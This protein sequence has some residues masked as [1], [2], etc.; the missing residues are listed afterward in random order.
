MGAS[1]PSAI[2][3]HVALRVA[4]AD[5]STRFYRDGLGLA[6]ETRFRLDGRRFV[7][8][9]APGGGRV[10][11]VEVGEEARSVSD[12]NVM[13]HFALATPDVRAAVA[14]AI[15]AGGVLSIPATDR[16]IVDDATSAA[17]AV[18]IA[19]VRGP[20]AEEIELVEELADRKSVV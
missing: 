20:D 12:S 6:V 18:R 7:H 9:V 13:W 19:F 8:L 10:E 16:T 14:A 17:R 3:H 4:D 1:P 5:R 15:S 11:L 2:L